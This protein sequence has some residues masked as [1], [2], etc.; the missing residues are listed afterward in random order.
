MA[1][2]ELGTVL[3]LFRLGEMCPSD[4]R[5]GLLML[6]ITLFLGLRI[7][8]SLRLGAK[9]WFSRFGDEGW[10]VAAELLNEE[11]SEHIEASELILEM[12]MIFDLRLACDFTG[13]TGAGGN[14]N[15]EW[16]VETTGD[17]L[18]F[19]IVGLAETVEILVEIT[20]S[21]SVLV[22]LKDALV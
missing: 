9:S 18:L 10:D 20:L 21:E 2:S 12:F 15:I 1:G 8:T 5:T 14:G 13:K 16:V 7:I 17:I 4:L 11:T 22:S 6:T 3:S 19:E